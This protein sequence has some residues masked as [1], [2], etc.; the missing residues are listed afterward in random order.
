MLFAVLLPVSGKLK[1]YLI[2]ASVPITIRLQ[3]VL[4]LTSDAFAVFKISFFKCQIINNIVIC[5]L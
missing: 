4:I 2:R 5:F 3:K 1:D